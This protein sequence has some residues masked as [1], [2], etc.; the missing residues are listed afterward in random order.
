MPTSTN[1]DP[2]A[3]RGHL[4]QEDLF[5]YAEGRL[6]PAEEHR[7]ELHLE[8]DPLLREA[9]EGLRTPGAT[10]GWARMER[11]RKAPAHGRGW[12]WVGAGAVVAF[13]AAWYVLPE[14]PVRTSVRTV[15][16]TPMTEIVPADDGP[17]MQATEIGSAVEVA[18]TL[19]IGHR[20]DDLHAIAMAEPV[21]RVDPLERMEH[22]TPDVGSDPER[23]ILST[24]N[25]K[26]TS[27]QL[28]YPYDLKLVHPK[29]LYTNDLLVQV[30]DLGVDASHA[31]L[32]AKTEAR[33]VLRTMAYTA[34]MERAMGRF[35]R[36]D[37]KAC[38]TDLLFLLEQYPEDVNALFYS[39]LCCYNLGLYGRART[40]L[41]KA[42][43]HS[44][45]VFHEEADWYHALTLER[46]GERAAA[47]AGF[48]RIA[49][50]QGF[51]SDR[52]AAA[53]QEP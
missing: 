20:S 52:A 12:F 19:M 5:A 23:S 16:L 47:R 17:V 32:A 39:G 4:S 18:E 42:S 40:F 14:R 9:L 38:L 44:I 33:P 35:A 45:G 34:Y 24:R 49:G 51:Y 15:S 46:L 11:P 26:R 13:L 31:D 30:D 21:E 28:F 10:A 27:V 6:S 8:N 22:I 29:D 53:L 1:T 2:F 50:E 43:T 7:V 25:G 48:A 36:N 3:P 41:H 37:H